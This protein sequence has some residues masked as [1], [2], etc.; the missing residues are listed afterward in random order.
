MYGTPDEDVKDGHSPSLH[1]V[2]ILL[3][4]RPYSLSAS[5][6]FHRPLWNYQGRSTPGLRPFPFLFT[7]YINNLLAEFEKDMF[8]SAY[9]DDLL[10]ARS[11]R[12]KNM[13]VAPLQPV[14]KVVVWSDKARLTHNVS[15]C[16]TAFFSLDCAEAA[17]QPNITIDG[18]QMFCN[19]TTFSQAPGHCGL[20]GNELADHQAKLCAAETQ[21][22]NAFDAA[23]WRALIHRSC[24]PSAIQYKRLKEVH[25]SLLDEQTGTS[26]CKMECADLARLGSGHHPEF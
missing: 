11:A 20:P 6:R 4:H 5:E 12:N 24:H 10:I 2:A 15:K 21:P 22:D 14:D 18:K 23:T 13:I 8:V 25:T 3:V 9:A 17:W 1:R 16:E 19:P 26:F 7:I